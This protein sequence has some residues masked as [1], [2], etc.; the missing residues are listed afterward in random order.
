MSELNRNLA[1]KYSRWGP[2][3]Y[4]QII[5]SSVNVNQCFKRL[6]SYEYGY[7]GIAQIFLKLIAEKLVVFRGKMWAKMAKE[8]F[9]RKRAHIFLFFG[10]VFSETRSIENWRFHVLFGEK[11]LKHRGVFH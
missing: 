4:Y 8:W 6:K 2:Y 7:G 3:Q 5:V 10:T 9:H 1:S 11:N